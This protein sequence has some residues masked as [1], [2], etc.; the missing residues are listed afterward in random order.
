MN[1][2]R[3]LN[4][5][6]N[7]LEGL[8]ESMT[9]KNKENSSKKLVEVVSV[10]CVNEMRVISPSALEMNDERTYKRQLRDNYMPLNQTRNSNQHIISRRKTNT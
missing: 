1:E 3:G 6:I 10:A 4:K 5:G 9:L 7:A 8:V 2:K